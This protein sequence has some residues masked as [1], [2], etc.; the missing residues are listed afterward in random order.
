MLQIP[1]KI[2]SF[3]DRNSKIRELKQ[4][5]GTPVE[6][7]CPRHFWKCLKFLRLPRDFQKCLGISGNA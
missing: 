2:F 5:A 1:T 6:K 4:I 3:F 7:H